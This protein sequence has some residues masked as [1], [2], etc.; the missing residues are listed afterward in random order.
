MCAPPLPHSLS[1]SCAG[2]AGLSAV[3]TAK[4]LYGRAGGHSGP[5]VLASRRGLLPTIKAARHDPFLPLS[6]ATPEGE[7]AEQSR[8]K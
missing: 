8:V 7:G 2:I 5:V 1:F 3:D 4:Q 6:V